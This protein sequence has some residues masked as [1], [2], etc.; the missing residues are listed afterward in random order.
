MIVSLLQDK[1]QQIMEEK[2]PHLHFMCAAVAAPSNESVGNVQMPV[3]CVCRVLWTTTSIWAATTRTISHYILLFV[4]I[5]RGAEA[6][7]LARFLFMSLLSVPR[8]HCE[9]WRNLTF[10]SRSFDGTSVM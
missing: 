4:I 8:A 9:R 3:V 5:I 1:Q 6:M 7:C 10:H 2:Q